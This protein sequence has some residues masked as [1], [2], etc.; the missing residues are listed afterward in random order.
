MKK[1]ALAALVLAFVGAC[2][3]KQKVE[4]TNEKTVPAPT[5]DQAPTPPPKN[6]KH[7]KATAAST[8]GISDSVKCTHDKD[9]RTIE[10]SDKD[11][12]CETVY[13]KMGEAKT[14]ATSAHGKEHCEEVSAK[15]QKNLSTAGFSCQ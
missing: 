8:A 10:V 5:K 11:G 13:T 14:I 4:Q 12:G 2:A 1:L 15:I 6:K 7:K 9:E 3:N